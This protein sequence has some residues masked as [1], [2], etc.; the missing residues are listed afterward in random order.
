MFPLGSTAFA[1]GHD[2][3]LGFH[4]T[5]HDAHHVSADAGAGFFDFRDRKR[6]VALE[7]FG[8]HAVAVTGY[9]SALHNQATAGQL[10]TGA[11]SVTE[12]T[13]QEEKKDGLTTG[14]GQPASF[15]DF[16]IDT[17]P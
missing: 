5:Q 15:S 2:Q 13:K 7:D 17:T 1:R 6:Q 8:A 4:G 12:H 11:V 10:T 9:K 3:P 16:K 14:G